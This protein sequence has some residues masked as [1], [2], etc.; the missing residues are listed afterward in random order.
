MPGAP[1]DRDVPRAVQAR[2]PSGSGA[3][4][5]MLASTSGSCSRHRFWPATGE[6]QTSIE[7]VQPRVVRG[8]AQRLVVNIERQRTRDAMS[9]GRQRQHTRSSPNV[10]H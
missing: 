5:R 6:L 1:A 8:H 3:R 4:A 2:A 10:E 7:P 9:Q